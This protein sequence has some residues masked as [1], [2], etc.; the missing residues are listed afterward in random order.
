MAAPQR[1]LI[2]GARGVIGSAL[3]AWMKREHPEVG[4]THL[5]PFPFSLQRIHE[6]LKGGTYTHFVNCAGVSGDLACTDSPHE[7]FTANVTGVLNQLEMVRRYSSATRYLQFGSIYED[8]H[9]SPYASTK[10]MAR[11]LVKS[12]RQDYDLYA[13]TAT[14][15]FTES[16][17]RP[18]TVLARKVTSGV[19]RIAKALKAGESFE[20]LQLRDIDEHFNWTWAEDVADGVWRMLNQGERSV[21]NTSRLEPVTRPLSEPRD[22]TLV[23]PVSASVREFV[24]LAFKE[25]DISGQWARDIDN[26]A[27]E[28]LR[29]IGAK[30]ALGL[31]T[32]V[33][34]TSHY[35]PSPSPFVDAAAQRDLNWSPQVSF[36]ELVR[37]MMACEREA[38]P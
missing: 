12:Y 11:E 17:V 27:P 2:A 24:E 20:P 35:P 18:S 29:Y 33:C 22:Y 6:A 38:N 34:V 3:A 4:L 16:C 8:N 28:S 26:P 14:L 36:P 21:A 37:R 13:V 15:G 30:D 23:N 9:D 10:R 5:Q 31:R 7:C 19:W 32:L 25:V 1:M